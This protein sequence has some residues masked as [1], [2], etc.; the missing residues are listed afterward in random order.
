L[1]S[2]HFVSTSATSLQSLRNVGLHWPGEGQ[3]SFGLHAFP[4]IVRVQ[5]CAK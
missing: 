2:A 3:T 4:N 5:V 1:Q